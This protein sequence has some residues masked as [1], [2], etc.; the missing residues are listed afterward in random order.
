MQARLD[1][2]SGPSSGVLPRRFGS[3]GA[4]LPSTRIGSM[5][6]GATGDRGSPP[7]Q[8]SPSEALASWQA[9]LKGPRR[10]RAVWMRRKPDR[11]WPRLRRPVLLWP[12]QP[13]NGQAQVAASEPWPGQ[14]PEPVRVWPRRP[15]LGPAG[16]VGGVATGVLLA[17]AG[18]A[19]DT[20]G[21]GDGFGR[22]LT[23][24]AGGMLAP[25]GAG[26]AE[27]F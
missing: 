13:P 24:A 25:L 11:V 8:S 10:R 23:G 14:Q 3:S 26:G 4:R 15:A 20:A 2:R 17:G 16:A 22:S 7:P 9:P 21:A 19:V 18:R 1:C 27:G 5:S 12:E 6:F